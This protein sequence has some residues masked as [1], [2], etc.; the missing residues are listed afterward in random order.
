MSFEY[1]QTKDGQLF[2]KGFY[3][4]ESNLKD[5]ERIIYSLEAKDAKKQVLLYVHRLN[6]IPYTEKDKKTA[7]TGK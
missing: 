2:E 6:V 5:G 4:T 1:I 7:F 3:F